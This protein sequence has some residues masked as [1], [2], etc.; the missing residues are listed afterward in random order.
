MERVHYRRYTPSKLPNTFQGQ[1][2]ANFGD[3]SRYAE[4]QFTEPQYADSRHIASHYRERHHSE[5]QG[6]AAKGGREKLIIQGIVSGMIFASVLMVSIMDN[7]RATGIKSD[8]NQAISNHVTAE[9]VA[10]EVT[11]ILEIQELPLGV[12]G[13]LE[14]ASGTD[15][16]VGSLEPEGYLESVGTNDILAPTVPDSPSDTGMESMHSPVQDG[17]NQPGSRSGIWPEFL[18]DIQLGPG[19]GNETTTRIDADVL[20]EAFGYEGG[21]IQTTAPEPLILPE[22]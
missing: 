9:Q 15:S 20:M 3:K 1:D 14:P 17:A 7:P 5:S 19:Q 6:S 16:Q 13:F 12:L 11:R 10:T 21:N 2:K 18:T 4:Q 22:L 8:L